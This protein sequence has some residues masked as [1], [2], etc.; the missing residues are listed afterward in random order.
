LKTAVVILNWNGVNLLQEF[1]PPLLSSCEGIA[2]VIVAD[3]A[4]TDNSVE[5]LR[6]SHPGVRLILNR[7]NNGYAGGYNEALAQVEADYYVLLN[8]DV[9]VTPDWI[10]VLQ[11]FMDRN[12]EVAVCQ[13]KLR[14]HRIREKFEYAGA[15]GGYIDMLGYPFCRGRIFNSLEIDH[16]QYNDTAETFW[17]SGACMMIR[18]EVFKKAGGFDESFFAHMEEIDLCWRILNMG[19][20]IGY[21][22]EAEVFHVGGATLPKNNPRKTFLNF[23]NNLTMLY[24]NLPWMLLVPVLAARIFLDLVAAIKFLLEGDAPDFI[25]V[26]KAHAAFASRV[27]TGKISRSSGIPSK[28]PK[29]VYRGSIVIDHYIK[30]KQTFAGLGFTV[31]SIQKKKA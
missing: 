31:P 26:L 29:T 14:W 15:A 13:P 16:G 10:G 12:P 20:K 18:S 9:E 28:L 30:R 8:S 27:I 25:A 17:A 21:T 4:S 2:E 24:K 6:N 1:I 7:S 11:D 19:Y 23:R 22:D 5:W 3:N